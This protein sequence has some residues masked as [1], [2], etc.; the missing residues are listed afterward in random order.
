MTVRTWKVGELAKRTGLTVRTLHHYDGIGLLSPSRRSG[1]GYRLYGEEDVARLQRIAS[2][3]Q[4]GFPL[5]AIRECLASPAWT[6]ERILALQIEQLRG[7]MAEERRLLRR[8]EA[9]AG[10][11]AQMTE[12]AGPAE[13][14]SADE[15][16]EMVEAMTMFEKYYTP[17]QLAQLEEGRKQLG[18]DHIR[19]V[20]QEWPQL[21]AKVKECMER[22]VDPTGD[23]MR[24]LAQRWRELVRE[25]TGGDPGIAQ[26]VSRLYENEPSARQRTGLD[27]EVMSYVGRAMAAI[28]GW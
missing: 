3:R 20:E 21:I 11:V 10:R 2:L 15:L 25:F 13:G 4:L 7:R 6:L 19:A 18:E 17:E 9:L 14:V 27:P 5:E 23:E 22:G 8:L 16:L 26:S 28:G 24:P 1:S 12:S